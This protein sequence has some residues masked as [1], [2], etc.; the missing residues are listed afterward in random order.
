MG[1]TLAVQVRHRRAGRKRPAQRFP[2]QLHIFTFRLAPESL[3]LR[4]ATVLVRGRMGQTEAI[5]PAYAQARLRGREPMCTE[6]RTV[7]A[8][9]PTPGLD[10]ICRRH[11]ACP[12]FLALLTATAGYRPTIRLDL[13]GHGGLVLARAYDRWQSRWGDPR[14]AFV[15]G[16]L[17]P[18]RAGT[19]P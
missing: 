10:A 14:R 16:D 12:S 18:R 2:D 15:T 4:F 7:P 6:I 3:H 19:A 1:E 13:M 17:P 8:P 9:R 11:T 5:G